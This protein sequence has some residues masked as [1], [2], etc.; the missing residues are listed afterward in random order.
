MSVETPVFQNKADVRKFVRSR[1]PE[2]LPL[3]GLYKN[4]SQILNQQKGRWAGFKAMADEPPLEG[5]LPPEMEWCFPKISGEKMQFMTAKT[6]KKSTM[7]FQEPVGGEVVS[8]E[9][10]DGFL[11]PGV[12][13]SRKGQ[14]VGRGKGFYDRA[15][16]GTRGLKVG[17]CYSYQMFNELP[18]EEHDVLMDVVVT[19]QEILWLT[20]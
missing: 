17:L 19:D 12:A 1:V 8:N 18:V 13:F 5:A 6:W 3:M 11:V 16:K 4:L 2:A 20:R 9:S 10:L 7:G 15:L 14:R